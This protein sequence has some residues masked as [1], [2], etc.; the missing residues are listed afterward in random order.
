MLDIGQ[1]GQAELV[2][3]MELIL[4]SKHNSELL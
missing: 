2:Q 4:Q 1:F 3:S